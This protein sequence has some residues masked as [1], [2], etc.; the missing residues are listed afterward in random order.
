MQRRTLVRAAA[1]ATVLGAAGLLPVR[2]QSLPKFRFNLGWRVEASGAGFILAQQ[3]GYYKDAGVDVQIDTGNGSA[4]AI[5]FVASGAYEAASADLA[6]MVE[7]NQQYPDRRLSAVAI[8]YDLNHNAILVRRDSPITKPADLAGKTLLGQPFNASRKLFPVFARAN[9][10]DGSGVQW[11]SADPQVGDTRF[12]K[13]DFDGAAYFYFTGLLNIKSRGVMPDQLRV[14]RYSDHGLK[15]YGNGIVTSAKVMQEQPQ[16]LA[17]FVK[18]SVRGWIDAI[19]EPKAAAAALKAREPLAY[20]EL[21]VERLGLIAGG[22]MLTPD[23]RA[24]GW[25][26]ATPARL[27]A[28]I[29]ETVAAFG[30]KP[31]M[32]VADIWSDR[33]LPGA[34]DR[35][36]KA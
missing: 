4:A 35:K 30:L 1:G 20:E 26:A 17:A 5:N 28:T 7:F 14:F 31:G 2:A 9:G 10:F 8:Q 3:R 16:A 23:T 32:T 18:A 21:E 25:G 19:A 27:Q 22:S 6:A 33:F 13:G 15:S 36:L 24:N 29:D 34:A 11:V 12:A